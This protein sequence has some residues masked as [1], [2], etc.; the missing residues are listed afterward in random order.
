MNDLLIPHFG[1]SKTV[2]IG[3]KYDYF[4]E[5]HTQDGK[6]WIELICPHKESPYG[7]TVHSNIVKEKTLLDA[8]TRWLSKKGGAA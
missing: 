6:G 4:I 3:E 7:P 2:E 5:W 1:V 8:Y